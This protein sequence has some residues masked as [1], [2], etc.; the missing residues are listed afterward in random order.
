M[1]Y[2]AILGKLRSKASILKG[3]FK[4][5]LV[6]SKT[7]KDIIYCI[8]ISSSTD[9]VDGDYIFKLA[10]SQ[11]IKAMIKENKIDE[12]KSLSIKY[13]I[14]CPC[15]S[16]FVAEKLIQPFKKSDIYSPIFVEEKLTR[17]SKQNDTLS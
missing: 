14:P 7:K 3:D 13:Q 11:S 8:D 17:I 9:L 10:A 1:T 5:N 2:L 6:N 15:T 16:F 12:A 4:I